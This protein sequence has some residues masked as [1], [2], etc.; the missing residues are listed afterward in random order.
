MTLPQNCG[1]NV[2][3]KQRSKAPSTFTNAN[4]TAPLHNDPQGNAMVLGFVVASLCFHRNPK[5]GSVHENTHHNDSKRCSR[6]CIA[7]LA[8]RQRLRS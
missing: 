4:T 2:S 3:A 8:W 1:K 7:A 6:N 5:Y